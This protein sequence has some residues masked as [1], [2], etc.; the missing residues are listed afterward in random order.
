MFAPFG[1]ETGFDACAHCRLNRLSGEVL[2]RCVEARDPSGCG[3]MYDLGTRWAGHRSQDGIKRATRASA[4]HCRRRQ[5]PGPWRAF[6]RDHF[7][8]RRT[9]S[10]SRESSAEFRSAA[11]RSA[12]SHLEFRV[13]IVRQFLASETIRACY[14]DCMTKTTKRKVGRPATGEG[15]PISVR[16][17]PALLA[18]VDREVKRLQRERPG[19]PS[20]RPAAIRE[21]LARALLGGGK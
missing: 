19:I 10:S 11:I 5:G 6:A 4:R 8:F 14:R 9:K 7:G 12:R 3:Q 16:L 17:H 1:T 20:S 18:A 21:T 15:M 13:G 2:A